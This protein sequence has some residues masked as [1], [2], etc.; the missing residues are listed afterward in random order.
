[1]ARKDSLKSLREVLIK[2]RDALRKAL[3][4]DLSSLKELREQSKG[5]VVD[6]ALDSA[7]DEISS[8]LAEVESRELGSIDAALE[9]M[10][11]GNYGKCEGCK[12]NIPLA[13]LQ[14]LP[15]ATCCIDCQRILEQEGIKSP[16]SAD[17]ANILD[18][19]MGDDATF[20]DVEV[21]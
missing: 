20:G 8:Q 18:T 6:F 5:D 13:R 1:M 3:A 16:T 4:G 17:W 9:R 2:R 11:E 7:Q 14:A 21:S 15:Y 19:G 12:T 10:R